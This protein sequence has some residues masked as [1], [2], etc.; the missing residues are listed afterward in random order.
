MKKLYKFQKLWLDNVNF[1]KTQKDADV[2]RPFATPLVALFIGED[3]H[4][5]NQQFMDIN[6]F[7]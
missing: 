1:I 6:L 7:F 2:M 5:M 4:Y 3:Q